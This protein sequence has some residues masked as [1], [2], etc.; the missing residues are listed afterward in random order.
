MKY[1][2]LLLAVVISSTLLLNL[3]ERKSEPI[4]ADVGSSASNMRVGIIAPLSGDYANYGNQIQRGVELAK[5]ELAQQGIIFETIYEDACIP[6]QGVSAA[7]RLITQEKVFAIVGNYCIASMVPNKTLIEQTKTLT[8][9]SSVVPSSLLQN[10]SYLFSTFPSIKEEGQ[11]LAD[12]ARNELKATRAGVLYLETAWGEEFRESFGQRFTELGGELVAAEAN[13]IGENNFHAE[14]LRIKQKKPDVLLVVHVG[15]SMGV[16]LKQAREL[17]L[18]QQILGPDEADD[19]S[20]LTAASYAAEGLIILSPEP[21]EQTANS[22]KFR[23]LFS[24]TYKSNSTTLSAHAYDATKLALAAQISC[25]T[26][27]PEISECLRNYMAKIKNYQGAS[28]NFS[29]RK[30]Q[31]TAREFVKKQVKNG[32]FS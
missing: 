3:E 12:Y 30:D 10:N 2:L 4:K 14:L 8:F 7:R 26:S 11:A 28:G 25:Q 22:Q 5:A 9:Q 1:A 31:T 17:K 6:Q 18:E 21:M 24:S 32:K 20:V 15:L 29:I 19:K 13:A 27:A 16:A 23:Q